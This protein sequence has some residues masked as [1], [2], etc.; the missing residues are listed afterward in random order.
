MYINFQNYIFRYL[1]SSCVLEQYNCLTLCRRLEV[2]RHLEC[3]TRKLLYLEKLESCSL[4]T[5]QFAIFISLVVFVLAVESALFGQKKLN[6]SCFISSQN[7]S[8]CLFGPFLLRYG[9]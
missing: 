9:G 7:P 8:S 4:L 5:L 1:L 3:S 6:G 2:E